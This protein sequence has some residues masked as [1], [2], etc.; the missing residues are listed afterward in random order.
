MP[1][2]T[3]PIKFCPLTKRAKQ[4]Q[5]AYDEPFV[6]TVKPQK[7]ELVLG[8]LIIIAIACLVL[9][10]L[11]PVST[12][13]EV[14][15]VKHI[16][17]NE[18]ILGT[19]APLPEAPDSAPTVAALPNPPVAQSS[20]RVNGSRLSR[21]SSAEP[22]AGVLFLV[23]FLP[24]LMITAIVLLFNGD[25][26][27]QNPASTLLSS[28]GIAVLILVVIPLAILA[29]VVVAVLSVPVATTYVVTVR[30]I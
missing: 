24:F 4:K 8:R 6:F 20:S 10:V 12:W 18:M 14:I 7:G 27:R 11:L 21:S 25:E 16:E 17:G 23:L 29:L 28:A 26:L 2:G 3:I 5:K 15:N 9:I 30:Q 19:K 1:L 22:S 13:A